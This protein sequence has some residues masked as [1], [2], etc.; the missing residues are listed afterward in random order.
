MSLQ[1][2]LGAFIAAVG[3]DIKALKAP[4]VSGIAR[5]QADSSIQW[6]KQSDGSLVAKADSYASTNIQSAE[7]MSKQGQAGAS[8]TAMA[9]LTAEEKG[10]WN[11]SLGE[12]VAERTQLAVV[13]EDPLSSS[14]DRGAI[15]IYAGNL[16]R[17]LFGSSGYSDF[18]Q[19]SDATAWTT[20][21][22]AANERRLGNLVENEVQYYKD[23]VGQ[24]HFRGLLER[25]TTWTLPI[26]LFTIPAGFRPA[27]NV[28]LAVPA[29]SGGL[30]RMVVTAATGV[31]TLDLLYSGSAGS[32]GSHMMLA[33][34]TYRAEQ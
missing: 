31:V 28:Y 9:I 33:P 2:R 20:V 23:A 24:V 11:E 18:V 34:L 16:S 4:K 17:L 26:T 25:T 1:T 19:K 6:I 10:V 13:Q 15:R 3:A 32:N 12:N 14:Q 8:K 5:G 7:F 29:S 27:N 21:S 30:Y 22:Y